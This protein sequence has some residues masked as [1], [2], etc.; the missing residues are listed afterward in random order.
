MAFVFTV[1]DLV[2]IGPPTS[3]SAVGMPGLYIITSV[4][5]GNLTVVAA[6]GGIAERDPGLSIPQSRVTSHWASA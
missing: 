4:S 3:A 6:E 5:G 1:G 2:R